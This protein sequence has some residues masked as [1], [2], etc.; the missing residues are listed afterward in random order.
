MISGVKISLMQGGKA[1]YETVS[2]AYGYYLFDAVYPGAYT[3]TAEAYPELTITTPVENLRVISSCLTDGDGD[4]A[5]SAEFSVESGGLDM[6]YN[7]GYILKDGQSAPAA[8]TAP[9]QKNW[10]VNNQKYTALQD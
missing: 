7:L 9:P 6:N 3:L 8:I 10:T 2:D 4:K 5:E 1:V